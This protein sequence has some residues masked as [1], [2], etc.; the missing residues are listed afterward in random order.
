MPVKAL[1]TD[2]VDGCPT[3]TEEMTESPMHKKSLDSTF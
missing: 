1:R 3:H 2:R